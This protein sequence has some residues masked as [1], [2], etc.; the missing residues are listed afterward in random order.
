[1]TNWRNKATL[2]NLQPVTLL[3]LAVKKRYSKSSGHV[4]EYSNILN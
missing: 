1:M 4:I 3:A 2:I